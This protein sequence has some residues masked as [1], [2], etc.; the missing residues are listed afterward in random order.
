MTTID[1]ATAYT[2]MECRK[3]F[4]S[5]PHGRCPCCQSQGIWPVE[6]FYLSQ[7]EKEEWLQKI[8]NLK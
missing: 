8:R 7:E 3:V 2:C 5:A 1:L 6:W 4:D